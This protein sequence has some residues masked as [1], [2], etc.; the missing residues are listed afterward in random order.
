MS[1]NPNS[2]LLVLVQGLM[3]IYL[4]LSGTVVPVNIVSGVFFVSGFILMFW[5]FWT[6]RNSTFQ[7]TPDLAPESVL[8]TNGP[9]SFSRHPMYGGIMLIVL[10]L[11][12]NSFDN[13]RAIAA[14]ILFIDLLV[15]CSI[16]DHQLEKRFGKDYKDYEAKTKKLIPFLY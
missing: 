11:L 3:L 9:Y 12:L 8:I 4:F 2:L 7:I 13:L 5:A 14:L 1:R 15:K 6:L 10:S 16:E